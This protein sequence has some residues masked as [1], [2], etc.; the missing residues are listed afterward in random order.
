M[1]GD[2]SLLACVDFNYPQYI[3]L[4]VGQKA[5][6]ALVRPISPL[7]M[8][9]K[10]FCLFRKDTVCGTT[11]ASRPFDSNIF[12]CQDKMLTEECWTGNERRHSVD[13]VG[14][15]IYTGSDSLS[16]FH[17]LSQIPFMA[18]SYWQVFVAANGATRTLFHKSSPLCLHLT[19]AV[20]FFK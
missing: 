20:C 1:S 3:Q 15:V 10:G 8:N 13:V 4:M 7:A 9:K 6:T 12:D 14:N 2:K 17:Q 16:L 18:T 5:C 19:I 11:G